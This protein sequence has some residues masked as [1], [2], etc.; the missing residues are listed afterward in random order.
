MRVRERIPVP[1]VRLSRC[2]TH[3]P[4]ATSLRGISPQPVGTPSRQSVVSPLGSLG[5]LLMATFRL[6]PAE[7][8]LSCYVWRTSRLACWNPTAWSAAC[9]DGVKQ[10]ET[11]GRDRTGSHGR[12]ESVSHLDPGAGV[13]LL[14]CP[15]SELPIG[16]S[17]FDPLM[18]SHHGALGQ[19]LATGL[20]IGTLDALGA[21]EM[22]PHAMRARW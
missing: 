3:T 2:S 16:L 12:I 4:L 13:V 22:E 7:R 1:L 9:R 20:Q 10:N 14:D 11:I 6:G 19:P 17:P 21:Q 18:R 8:W 5:S 15:G